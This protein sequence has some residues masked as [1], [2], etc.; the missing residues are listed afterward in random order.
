MLRSAALAALALSAAAPFPLH[1]QWAGR[2]SASRTAQLDAEGVRLVRI[3]ARAGQLTVTGRSGLAQVTVRGTARSNQERY[4]DDIRLVA[5]RRGDVVRIVVDIPVHD[6]RLLRNVERALDLTIELPAGI[7]VDVRDTSGDVAIAGTGDVAVEDGSG[8]VTI[9]RIAG[10]VR[11]T[12]GSGDVEVRD[13]S[14]TVTIE[15]DGSG[16]LR[17]EDVRGSVVVEED[18]SGSIAVRRVGGSFTVRRDGSGGIDYVAVQG[19][20]SLPARYARSR[21]RARVATIRL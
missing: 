21:G 6:W 18:G 15:S 10:D 7:P 3:D 19:D 16:N 4:L 9:E 2:Y 5:E 11:V 1:A 14:G 12:D 17:I 13:V 20:V 8:T